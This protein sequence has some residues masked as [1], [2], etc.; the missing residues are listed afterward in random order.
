M[1]S[2]SI[3]SILYT[4]PRGIGD[5]MFSLPLLHSLKEAY[6]ESEIY[7]SIPKDKK[8]V[9]DLIG[10]VK[11]T[12]NFLPKP[13]DD[14]LAAERWIA[15][16]NGDTLRKYELERL[17][18]E[19]YL[20]GSF[21]LAIIPKNFKIESIDCKTQINDTDVL[22]KLGKL[23][24]LHMVERFSRFADYLE[25]KRVNS[26]ELDF[27]KDEPATLKDGS[28]LNLRDYI[29]LNLDASSPQ[30]VWSQNG[31]SEIISWGRK[32]G[33]S[34]VLVGGPN[35]YPLSQQLRQKGITNTVKN[36]GYAFD[37]ENIAKLAL[38]SRVLL[39]PDTGVLHVADAAGAKVVGLYGPTS[40]EKYAPWNNKDN[41]ISRFSSDKKTENISSKEVVKKLEEIL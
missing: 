7:L 2:K 14:S 20:C 12:L 25:I 30:K 27:D 24:N 16:Q 8:E 1:K 22:K 31:Y 21:D 36:K 11:P 10:F 5:M 33:F 26:F 18:Y 35:S 4:P 32:K 37:L 34:I 41:V 19:K 6:S 15:S 3:K 38:H 40:P 13:S 17:I 28:D 39:S 23:D 29:V 9:L